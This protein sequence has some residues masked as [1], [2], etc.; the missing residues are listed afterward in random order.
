MAQETLK[1]TITADTAEA[2]ANLNNFIKTSKGLKTEMQ[3]FGNVSGQATNALS[4]LSR[5]AQDAP[6]GFMGIAN[7][8]NPLLESFQR[9]KVEAGSSSGALKAMAQGLIGPA[10]IGLALGA[11]SS[12]IVAFGPKIMDFINGTSK[13]TQVED[14]F[15]TSLRDARAEASETGIRLQSYLIISESAN[16]SEERRA[17]ALKAV[18]TELSKVNS[19]YA[20]T[21]T[22]VDQARAAVDL[23]T[24]ALVNQALTTRYIDKIADKTEALNDVNK[25]ILQSGRDYFKTIDEQN[26][27]IA[28]GR[29]SAAVDQAVAAKELKKQNIEA[30]KEG[31]ALKNEIIDTRVVVKDLL[32]EA[33]NNPF[34]NFTKG[35]NEATNATNNTTKSIEK[36]GKQARVLKVGTTAI[37]ETENKITTPETPNKL[38]KDLPMFAQQYTADQ[39]FKNEAA[40]RRYNTQLQIANGITDTLTPAFEAMFSA[41]A[42][43]ENIG[44]ALEQTFKNILVQLSTMIIK[45]LIFKGIMAALGI[46]TAGAGGGFTNFNPIGAA[47]DGGGAFV[48]RGQ[49]LLLATNRAQ[50]ASNLKGQN[51]SLA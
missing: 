1:L 27:L 21:I 2:L 7:N 42:N 39:I 10:G 46:P 49:D 50:K 4:N 33:S 14:K 44:K 51:I 30:R 3:N 45:T 12:I 36:L 29:I 38:S 40:L 24:K 11:V 19:A 16:V 25:K 43:G 48:L 13:A 9:L 32:V 35:A 18:V 23:Y 15:A 5:V 26:R 17:E 37:I 20:S 41:M 28:E 8:L 31:N 47:G 6:Y 34:Y 22:N